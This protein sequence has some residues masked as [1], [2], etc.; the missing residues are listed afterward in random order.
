MNASR[1]RNIE[2]VEQDQRYETLLQ[3]SDAHLPDLLSLS[4]LAHQVH[5]H[6]H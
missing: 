1:E 6:S 3:K 5:A 2:D 4:E